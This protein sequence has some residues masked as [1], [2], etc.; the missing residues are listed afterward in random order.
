MDN[1]RSQQRR[2]LLQAQPKKPRPRIPVLTHIHRERN[3]QLRADRIK[4]QHTVS[5]HRPRYHNKDRRQAQ[6]VRCA[7]KRREEFQGTGVGDY[8]AHCQ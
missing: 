1:L 4:L 3:Q 6:L 5:R 2:N 8:E 7:P